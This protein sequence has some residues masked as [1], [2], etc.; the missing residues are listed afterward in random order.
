MCFVFIETKRG[1]G[2]DAGGVGTAAGGDSRE[3]RA[4]QGGGWSGS[5][6]ARYPV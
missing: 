1:C 4:A 3:A 5:E 6:A 2:R